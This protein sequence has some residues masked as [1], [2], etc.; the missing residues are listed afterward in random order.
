[1][2]SVVN[3]VHKHSILLF[4]YSVVNNVDLLS[5]CQG[6]FGLMQKRA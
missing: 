6:T 1:M 4:V 3:R 5:E 2:L